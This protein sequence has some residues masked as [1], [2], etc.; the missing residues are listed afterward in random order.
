M[1]WVQGC[2]VG[3]EI[4]E[5]GG[6]S[7]ENKTLHPM[8][9]ERWVGSGQ[10]GERAGTRNGENKVWQVWSVTLVDPFEILLG[11]RESVSDHLLYLI[12]SISVSWK[13]TYLPTS[14]Q[15]H[16]LFPSSA[17][18]KSRQ[19]SLVLH[20]GPQKTQVSGTRGLI[21]RLWK[22]AIISMPLQAIKCWKRPSFLLSLQCFSI[23]VLMLTMNLIFPPV[24]SAWTMAKHDSLVYLLIKKKE[25]LY[26]F[27]KINALCVC[28]YMCVLFKLKFGNFM[29][30]PHWR[31]WC[32]DPL[33]FSLSQGHL[34]YLVYLA[35]DCI[36]NTLSS[37]F[38][39]SLF[40]TYFSKIVWK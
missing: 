21:G 19:L 20:S 23:M 39:G 40:F 30:S 18:Q 37:W 38:S 25:F 22:S 27:E 10:K 11:S 33:P 14:N 35:H 28:V 2:E 31:L 26:T 32:W 17:G 3:M 34:E 29:I 1:K 4:Q 6:K 24:S 15:T 16:L 8:W 36:N 12:A 5:Q 13:T 7:L 9:R